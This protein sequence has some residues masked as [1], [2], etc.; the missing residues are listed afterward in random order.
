IACDER[1]G[2]LGEGGGVVAL[3]AIP[4]GERGGVGDAIEEDLAVE[5]VDLVL[6]G[7]RREAADLPLPGVALAVERA[8]A[9]LGVT[10][11]DAA[12]VRHAE[13]SL[14]VVEGL[15]AE[16]LDP[17]VDQNRQRNVRLVGI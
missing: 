17:R 15:L 13:A 11:H 5:V 10:A 16:R 9:D 12:E 4:G 1:S 14:V 3:K 7:A 8:H 6:E 2:A